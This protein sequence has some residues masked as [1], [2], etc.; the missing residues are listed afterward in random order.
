MILYNPDSDNVHQ[1][2]GLTALNGALIDD[3]AVTVTLVD[4]DNI[5]VPGE[6]W[7]LDMPL[8]SSGTYR[9]IVT[10]DVDIVAG[11]KYYAFTEAVS[12]TYGTT[13]FRTQ[14]SVNY[15]C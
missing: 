8:V 4:Y 12:P 2:Q 6:T 13:I 15:P 7:P 3:A 11:Q 9:N 1:L 5:E 14:V 10:K